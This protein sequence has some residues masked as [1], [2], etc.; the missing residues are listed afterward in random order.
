M[1]L[2]TERS[3][4]K[5][6]SGL[7]RG[8]LVKGSHLNGMVAGRDVASRVFVLDERIHVFSGPI[9]NWNGMGWL[10]VKTQ[11]SCVPKLSLCLCVIPTK[12]YHCV[13]SICVC[14]IWAFKKYHFGLFTLCPVPSFD[15]P[16]I[17][18]SWGDTNLKIGYFTFYFILHSVLWQ[19]VSIAL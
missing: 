14:C 2:Q 17:Q 1:T 7:A 9:Q 18:V 12:I 5:P 10:R 16:D 6:Q 11:H 8:F 15:P 3:E 4:E 19:Y 13:C